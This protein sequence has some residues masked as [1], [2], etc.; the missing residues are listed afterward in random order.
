MINEF[1]EYWR[2]ADR[3]IVRLEMILVD[4]SKRL[5]VLVREANMIVSV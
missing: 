3:V 4:L 5:E 2:D 1:I